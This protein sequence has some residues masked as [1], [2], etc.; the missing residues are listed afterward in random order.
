MAAG[1]FARTLNDL[2]FARDEA[3]L[4]RADELFRGLGIDW[5]AGQTEALRRLRSRAGG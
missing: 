2:G 3:L 1:A 4:D 5:Y